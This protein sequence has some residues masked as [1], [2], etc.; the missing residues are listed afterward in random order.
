MAFYILPFCSRTLVLVPHT[1]QGTRFQHSFISNLVDITLSEGRYEI[2]SRGPKIVERD[3]ELV[4][5]QHI[6]CIK[7]VLTSS[8][9]SLAYIFLKLFLLMIA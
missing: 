9:L 6:T 5:G 1:F 2:M 7:K 3:A 4:D 8:I